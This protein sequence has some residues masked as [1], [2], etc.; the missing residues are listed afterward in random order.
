MIVQQSTYLHLS[1]CFEV[2]WTPGSLLKS[3]S[4]PREM[5][6]CNALC[7]VYPPVAQV[8]SVQKG[9]IQT[10]PGGI[11]FREIRV[12]DDCEEDVIVFIF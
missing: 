12:A 3:T 11:F 6:Y 4:D 2:T 1:T 9:T 8:P 5:W 7:Q 10:S